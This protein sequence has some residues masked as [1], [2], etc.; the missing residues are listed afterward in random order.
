MRFF[1]LGGRTWWRDNANANDMAKA[2][3]RGKQIQAPAH[4][5][6]DGGRIVQRQL[7]RRSIAVAVTFGICLQDVLVQ[8]T[9]GET[10]DLPPAHELDHHESGEDARVTA[11][12]FQRRV[13]NEGNGIRI[14]KRGCWGMRAR[15]GSG[16]KP[17][18]P[19]IYSNQS[20]S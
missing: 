4:Q 19:R 13:I 17:R 7:V 20:R 12:R 14:H 2:K 9:D 3:L 15:S 8:T 11:V 18:A 1:H 10:P 5:R 6:Y 16:L